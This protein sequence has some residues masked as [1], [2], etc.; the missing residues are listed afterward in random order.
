MVLFARRSSS[1]SRNR[2]SRCCCRHVIVPLQDLRE[3]YLP[4]NDVAD[5]T[6]PKWLDHLQA[7][8]CL[9]LMLRGSLEPGKW[10]NDG[11]NRGSCL[12]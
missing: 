9:D 5:V 7:S 8:A 2:S 4:F 12:V 6:W 11:E 1:S 10:A 3:L